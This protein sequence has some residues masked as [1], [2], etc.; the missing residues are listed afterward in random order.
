MPDPIDKALAQINLTSPPHSPPTLSLDQA[1]K[2]LKIE[3]ISTS[4][5]SNSV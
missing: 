2:H 5:R 1:P 3:M 4:H